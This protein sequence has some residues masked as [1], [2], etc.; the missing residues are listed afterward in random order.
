MIMF[1][2]NIQSYKLV[3]DIYTCIH[4]LKKIKKINEELV[5]D[6]KIQYTYLCVVEN[7]IYLLKIFPT[8]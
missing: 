2:E 6:I 3:I 1:E 4:V 7:N 8:L 5:F